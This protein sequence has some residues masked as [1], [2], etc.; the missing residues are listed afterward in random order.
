MLE[1]TKYIFIDEYDIEAKDK[2][3]EDEEANKF[4]SK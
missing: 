1:K 2:E 4:I 3:L